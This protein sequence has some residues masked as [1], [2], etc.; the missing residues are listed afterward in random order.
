MT[1]PTKKTAKTSIL[2]AF[3]TLAA[4]FFVYELSIPNPVILLVVLMIFFTAVFSRLAGAISGTMIIIY[5]LFYFSSYHRFQVYTH[6]SS[7]KCLIIIISL[8]LIYLLVSRLRQY[9]DKACQELQKMN[10]ELQKENRDLEKTSD[11]D[12]LTGI[13]NRRGGH[14]ALMRFL[15]TKAVA[16]T[17]LFALMDIDNFKHFNDVYGHAVGDLVLQHLAR[18]MK[19]SFPADSECIRHGGDEFLLLLKNPQLQDLEARLNQFAAQKFHFLYQGNVLSYTISCGYVHYPAQGTALKELFT[20]ADT[21]LYTA[22]M[23][24]KNKAAMAR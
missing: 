17:A 6:E 20:K 14:K 24:G 5:A 16:K 4:I 1:T 18:E 7:Y 3:C 15:K 19:I 12:M 9:A 11:Y 13:Y 2:A 21:A 22:K 23:N 10:R 8:A